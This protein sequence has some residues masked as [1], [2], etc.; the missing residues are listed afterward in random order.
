MGITQKAL[1]AGVPVCAVPFGRDQLEVARHVEVAGAG[2]RLL[3]R[4]LAPARLRAAVAAT[5]ERRPGAERIAA[6]FRA[7]GGPARAADAL[8]SLLPERAGH[9]HAAP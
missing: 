4:R 7:A 1:S 3:P 8:E 2:V 6:A 5:R 9:A